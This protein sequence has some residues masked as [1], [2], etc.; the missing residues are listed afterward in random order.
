MQGKT[1]PC[2]LIDNSRHA[3]P[4]SVRQALCDKIHAPPFVPVHRWPVRHALPLSPFLASLGSHDRSLFSV[5]TINALG[6]GAV[7]TTPSRF[8]FERGRAID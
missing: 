5:E 6:K 2:V 1:L 8:L 7:P 3:D 4:A